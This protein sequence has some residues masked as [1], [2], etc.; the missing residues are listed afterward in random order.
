MLFQ[1]NYQFLSGKRFNITPAVTTP[2]TNNACQA[3]KSPEVDG[4]VDHVAFV[5]HVSWLALPLSVLQQMDQ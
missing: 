5:I 3:L 4:P 2:T 1:F